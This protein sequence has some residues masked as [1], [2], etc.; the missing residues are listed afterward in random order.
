VLGAFRESE[1]RVHDD[2]VESNAVG[3]GSRDRLLKLSGDLL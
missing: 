1:A 3:G 2:R